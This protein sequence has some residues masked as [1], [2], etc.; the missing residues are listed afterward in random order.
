MLWIFFVIGIA[1]A[2]STNLIGALHDLL[3]EHVF[4]VKLDF[5]LSQDFEILILKRL[6]GVM[7]PLAGDVLS[8]GVGHRLT[9]REGSI[10]ALSLGRDAGFAVV[11]EV[12]D[13][14]TGDHV[15]PGFQNGGCRS[16][17]RDGL[18][19]LDRS[20]Q[21]ISGHRMLH[22]ESAAMFPPKELAPLLIVH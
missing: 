11:I 4:Q 10:A 1:L 8:D 17:P 19:H 21:S 16:F 3:F 9:D 18:I 5:M 6:S 14:D 7:L 20:L 22:W 12:F 2:A 13:G 15:K